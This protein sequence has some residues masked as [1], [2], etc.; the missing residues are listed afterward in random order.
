M[1][2]CVHMGWMN[3]MFV[4]F[5]CI[6]DG[7]TEG[8]A[9]LDFMARARIPLVAARGVA[10]RLHPPLQGQVVPWQH[11][12]IQHRRHRNTRRRL[13]LQLRHHS[14][15]GFRSAAEVGRRVQRPGGERRPQRAAER[16]RVQFRRGGTGA[17]QRTRPAARAA[18]RR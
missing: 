13:R 16:R 7:S 15:H 1:Y 18:R 14:A 6:A 9:R 12:V 4:F 2:Y 8:R 3:T 11:Q 17:A 5:S 10:F